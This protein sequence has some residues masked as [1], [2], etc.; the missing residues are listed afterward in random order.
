M[1]QAWLS[2]PLANDPK[3]HLIFVGQNDAGEYGDSL[4]KLI[5]GSPAKKRI[6]ITGWANHE[7]FHLY[8][9]AA[10][11]GVQLRTLSRGE[12][13]AAVL[14]CMNYGLATIVNAHGSM[15]NLILMVCGC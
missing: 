7:T 5:N 11:I 2:S 12:T 10:D 1:L 15:V 9:S 14:D 6:Y 3:A 8:L 4:R 13:S